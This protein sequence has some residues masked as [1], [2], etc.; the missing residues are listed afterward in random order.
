MQG[1]IQWN[2]VCDFAIL[3]MRINKKCGHWLEEK[4]EIEKRNDRES[5]NKYPKC[6]RG[7]LRIMI[8][9]PKTR[10]L[11]YHILTW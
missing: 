1:G 2:S 3:E 4:S 10:R 5:K 7:S 8:N 6:F 9:K 11:T